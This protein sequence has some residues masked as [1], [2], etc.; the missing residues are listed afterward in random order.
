MLQL[1][2]ND[3]EAAVTLHLPLWSSQV[4]ITV[5]TQ[6]EVPAGCHG[7]IFKHVF[8]E[9]AASVSPVGPAG[10]GNAQHTKPIVLACEKEDAGIWS[11]L[12]SPIFQ[13][14]MR[15]GHPN[16]GE[17]ASKATAVS[18]FLAVLA[19][20][21][22]RYRILIRSDRLMEAVS[23]GIPPELRG[24]FWSVLCNVDGRKAVRGTTSTAAK[25]LY[26]RLCAKPPPRGSLW[27]FAMNNALQ[28]VSV[29][30]VH[31]RLLV[32]ELVLLVAGAA[33]QSVDRICSPSNAACI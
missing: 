12:W 15:P 4:V 10:S 6:T 16:S 24:E 30:C 29:A 25:S 3:G 20:N 8:D 14:A 18:V 21:R 28:A 5:A 13:D 23:R 22:S 32:H 9:T 31:V 27:H 17:I 33:E 2:S 11:S 19:A 7:I 26:E 1:A